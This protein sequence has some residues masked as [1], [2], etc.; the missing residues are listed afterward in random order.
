MQRGGWMSDNALLLSVVT[1][2]KE[3]SKTKLKVPNFM[4]IINHIY[5]NIYGK[6]ISDSALM[7]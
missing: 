1:P 3:F 7:N 6:W 4:N 5:S 2:R